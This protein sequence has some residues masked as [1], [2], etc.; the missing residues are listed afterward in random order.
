[1]LDA[2]YNNNFPPSRV[3]GLHLR[4]RGRPTRGPWFARVLTILTCRRSVW[5]FGDDTAGEEML[6][7]SLEEIIT[8]RFQ[9]EEVV[10]AVEVKK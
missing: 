2:V 6:P 4:E 7:T 5:I 8:N 10:G 1:M 9:A 3:L